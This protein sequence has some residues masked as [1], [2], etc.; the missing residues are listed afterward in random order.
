MAGHGD[1]LRKLEREGKKGRFRVRKEC[2]ANTA[3]IKLQIK[4]GEA[5]I[6]GQES[7]DCEAHADAIRMDALGSP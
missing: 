5:C 3:E 6:R 7:G 1:I 4:R 2:Q